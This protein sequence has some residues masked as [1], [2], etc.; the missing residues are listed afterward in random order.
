MKTI[1]LH[2]GTHK[3]GT[4]FL[5]NILRENRDKLR[6]F[7]Y[8][9]P[10]SAIPNSSL[11]GHHL[12]PRSVSDAREKFDEISKKTIVTD[13]IWNELLEELKTQN[14]NKI[15]ISSEDFCLLDHG[16]I[17]KVREYLRDFRVEII[18]YLR[19]QDEFLLS[20]YSE[21]VKKGYYQNLESVLYEYEER[22]DY[23]SL[24]NTWADVFAKDH[25]KVG[26]YQKSGVKNNLLFDFLAKIDLHLDVQDL[27]LNSLS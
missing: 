3:T 15:I 12:L 7:D 21:L 8:Y 25:L 1:Y 13:K 23:Y 9:Y 5:Q 4:T 27:Q 14:L 17:L 6:E 22:F 20:L 24:L 16:E 2:I 19:R 18:V 10:R 11:P 26:I